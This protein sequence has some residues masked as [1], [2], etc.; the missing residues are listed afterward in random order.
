MKKIFIK[1]IAIL[2][3]FSSILLA[4]ADYHVAVDGDDD[5]G[6]GSVGKPWATINKAIRTVPDGAKVIVHAGTYWGRISLRRN[7]SKGITISAE[8]LYQVKLRNNDRVI[9]SYD[10][11]VRGITIEGFDIAHDGPGAGGLVIHLDGGGANQVSRITLRN[12]IL[13]DSY[14]NDIL[15]INNAATDI[16]V[17]GNVFY[18]QT[19]SDEH[20]DINSAADVTVQDNIFFNDFEGSGRSNYNNT[21]SYIV[22]K[23]S[24]GSEDIFTGS[25]NVKIRRNIFLN[26]QGSTGS[27]FVLIGEDGKP[28]HEADNILVENNLMLGNSSHLMR[29][30]FGVKGGKNIT[31]RHNTVS[32]DL[33]SY[34]F[35]MRLNREGSNPANHNIAFYNNIWVD[36]TGTM[37]AKTSSGSNDFSDTPIN[38]TSSFSINN[39]IY[40]NG[41]DAIPQD[42]SDLIN[43]TDDDAARLANPQINAPVGISVP[44]WEPNNDTFTGDFTS[45]RA[46]FETLVMNYCSLPKGSYAVNR[47]DPA[48]SPNH[49]ILSKA[50]PSGSKSD[51]GACEYITDSGGGGGANGKASPFIYLLLK[52]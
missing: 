34:A 41:G 47:A 20:I 15:K 17:T 45:I 39:N 31:F 21:S 22:I 35:A 8:P 52:K 27:N 44:R 46:A 4:K 32:G 49:D 48:E 6:T 28:Y 9:T 23:D 5:S 19:G 16:T 26:W 25:T 7:F 43:Y 36:Q 51:I 13:H 33:P 2:L 38:D 24:N 40:W 12:N 50:R 42:S 30:P 29:A 3:F 14:N 1:V 11:N 37:G 10:N 18:N